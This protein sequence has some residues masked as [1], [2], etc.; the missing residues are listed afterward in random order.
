MLGDDQKLDPGP[1]PL[2]FQIAER[3]RAAVESCKFAPGD[4]LPSETEI[5]GTFGVS[6]TT[7]RSALDRL[8]NEG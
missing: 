3:L 2:W 7:A 8:E 6:R 1:I 4:C 5:N